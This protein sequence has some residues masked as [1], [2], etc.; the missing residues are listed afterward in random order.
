MSIHPF[1]VSSEVGPCLGIPA[2]NV[3][4]DYAGGTSVRPSVVRGDTHAS[5]S[6]FLECAYPSTYGFIHFRGIEVDRDGNGTSVY[7]YDMEVCDGPNSAEVYP[8]YWWNP[9]AEGRTDTI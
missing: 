1:L 3:S 5:N 8:A 2:F 6:C 4:D 9:N 7:K